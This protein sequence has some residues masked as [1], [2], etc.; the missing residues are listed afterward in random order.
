M[1]TVT[2]LIFTQMTEDKTPGK[3]SALA[4]KLIATFTETV[5]KWK[6]THVC[7]YFIK[8]DFSFIPNS[9]SL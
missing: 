8:W 3:V 4:L 7:I 9:S 2:I 5:Q 1:G 6:F